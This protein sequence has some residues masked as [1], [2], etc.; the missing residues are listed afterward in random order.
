MPLLNSA[1]DVRIGTT[2]ATRVY[3]GSVLVWERP[4]ETA[5]SLSLSSSVI[6]AGASITLTATA[7]APANSTVNFR[8]GSPT[9]PIVGTD[10]SYPWTAVVTPS[11]TTTYYAELV[12]P[13]PYLPAVSTSKTV[14]VAQPTSISLA[15]SS[16]TV[17]VGQSVTLTATLTGASSGTVRFR[18]GSTTGSIIASDTASP[19]QAT[20]SPAVG[21]TT[22]YATYEPP[23]NSLQASSSTGQTVTTY[24]PT[25]VTLAKSGDITS[26]Q[27]VTLTATITGASTGTVRFRSGS[28]SGTIVAT[29]SAS[30][31]KA[32]ASLSP[33][34]TTTYYAEY[35]AS[36]YVKGSF[37]S[38]VSV[39]VS[40]PTISTSIPSLA[41][42]S[43]TINNGQSVTLTATV[44][45]IPAGQTI[46]FRSGSTTGTVVGSATVS[47]TTAAV[48]LSPSSTTN[49]YA[50]YAGSGV[51]LPSN[52]HVRT[53]T[54]RQLV[55]KTFSAVCSWS[56]SYKGNGDKRT[57][58]SDCY[59]GYYSS[60]WGNQKS[61]IGWDVP[62]AVQ[63]CVAITE[64]TLEIYN[65]HHY[66][67]SG[68]EMPLGTHTKTS[69]PSTWGVGGGQANIN[70]TTVPKTGWKTYTLGNTFKDSFKDDGAKGIAVGPGPTTSTHYYG[71]CAGR[72]S[73]TSL[74]PTL[75]LKYQVWE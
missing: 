34:A 30:A 25:T 48:T 56:Q 60:T 6:N 66:E 68:G 33:T 27:S 7:D 18:T 23:N 67:N 37:S 13:D 64:A 28:T 1:E 71:Y 47:G 55:T 41:A 73:G 20:V 75:T 58:T 15:V 4:V 44:S 19:W 17:D 9:G 31:G 62:A 72:S 46:Q 3:S 59:Y 16:S 39:T 14:T 40:P 29:V 69:A 70:K 10:S 74:R 32:T 50:T 35:V 45:N 2:P 21:Q 49:Y 54:V 5:V 8:S 65:L 57:D 22:Y 43:T 53:V 42:S 36:G 61:L 63:G 38:G 52:S 26:G 11:A 24:Q 51:Y 12:P